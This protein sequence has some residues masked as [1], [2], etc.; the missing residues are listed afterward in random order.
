VIGRPQGWLGLSGRF[1]TGSDAERLRDLVLMLS[2]VGGLS[3]G[4]LDRLARAIAE[5][6]EL[7]GLDWG[8]VLGREKALENEGVPFEKSMRKVARRLRMAPVDA[9]VV[10]ADV[11]LGREKASPDERNL[12]ARFSEHAKVENTAFQEL[13]RF[14]DARSP[15][16][17]LT[18]YFRCPANAPSRNGEED[19]FRAIAHTR[20]PAELK[21]LIHKL[22]AVRVAL[23]AHFP[24]A[25]VLELGRVE[26]VGP[27]RLTLDAVIEQQG[28]LVYSRFLAPD[29][30]LHPK[31]A[32]L[33][34]TFLESAP[35]NASIFVGYASSL[36]PA[37]AYLLN[38]LHSDRFRVTHL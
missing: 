26:T 20:S 30:A 31:E 21:L 36:S 7:R 18:G 35:A 9:M 4:K 38:N 37:D 34:A 10:A 17:G 32:N 3:Q 5:R 6:P 33:L 28:H 14:L 13:L 12:L 15:P 22:H 16:S 25:N 24:S 27:Y 1:S 23:T 2:L 11:A 8:L 19:L 29:E